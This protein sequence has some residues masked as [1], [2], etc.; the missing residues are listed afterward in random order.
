M[1]KIIPYT[2]GAIALYL[3]VVWSSNSGHVIST[4]ATGASTVIKSLQGR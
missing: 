3:V 2:F 4:S 1:R